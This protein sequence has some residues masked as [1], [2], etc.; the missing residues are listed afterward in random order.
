MQCRW[1]REQA[2]TTIAGA[3]QGTRGLVKAYKANGAVVYSNFISPVITSLTLG[4][5]LTIIS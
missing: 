1:G 3:A 5:N 2:C 4:T